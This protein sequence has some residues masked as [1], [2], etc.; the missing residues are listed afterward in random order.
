M[1]GLFGPSRLSKGLTQSRVKKEPF[2]HLYPWP[3]SQG[4]S[5]GSL[6]E[7]AGGIQAQPLPRLARQ[8]SIQ[9]H[10]QLLL[11][12]PLPQPRSGRGMVQGAR[13]WARVSGAAEV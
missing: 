6:S 2:F 1:C 9:L 3:G 7:G 8:G 4:L 10:S 11:T 12:G 5:S 13:S